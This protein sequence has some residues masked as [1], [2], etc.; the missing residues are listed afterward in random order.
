MIGLHRGLG[1]WRTKVEIYVALTELA[2][3]LYIRAGLPAEKVTVKPNFIHPSPPP[4]PGGGGY[5]LFVGRLSEE[6]GIGPLLRAWTKANNVIPLKVVGEGPL[7]AAVQAAAQ[8]SERIEFIGP[9]T[10][11]ETYALTQRAEFLVFPSHWYEGMPRTVIE[12]LAAGTPVIASNLGAMA[13]MIA[14]GKTGWLFPASDVRALADLSERCSANLAVARAMRSAA[15]AEF[16][17]TYTGEKNLG[18]LLGIY[19]RACATK[20]WRAVGATR[21]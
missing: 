18:L 5:A 14:D 11:Q 12:A 20:R 6:K 10:P 1:T 13:M 19:D 9:R 16:E 21:R 17:A 3:G 15:R 2:R 8:G 7:A 4:G